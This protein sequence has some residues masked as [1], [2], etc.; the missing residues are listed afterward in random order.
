MKRRFIKTYL[1]VLFVLFVAVSVLFVKFAAATQ[2]LKDNDISSDI[3]FS[4]GKRR[5]RGDLWTTSVPSIN[6]MSP[7]KGNLI[8]GIYEGVVK[9]M[10]THS[11]KKWNLEITVTRPCYLNNAWNGFV[12][13][14]RN[15][16]L[17]FQPKIDLKKARETDFS[18]PTIKNLNNILIPLEPGDRIIFEPYMGK[19]IP[20]KV[21]DVN[22]VYIG[23]IFYTEETS[24]LM[25]FDTW[26]I[27]YQFEHAI[28]FHPLFYVFVVFYIVWLY[29]VAS[30]F[31]FIAVK[32]SEEHDRKRD[33]LTIEQV[34]KVFTRFIDAKD[35]YTAGH[36][37][38]VGRYS[39]KIAKEMGK[40][41]DECMNAYYCGLLHDCGKIAV[42]DEIIAKPDKLTDEE[43]VLMQEHTI[44]GYAILKD[45]TLIPDASFAAFYHHERFDG[46]GYPNGLKGEEIPEIVR[47]V[48]VAD[49][50]DCMSRDRYYRK[51]FPLE[52]IIEDFK[53]NSGKQFDP[54]VLNAFFALAEKGEFNEILK[55]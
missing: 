28:F 42:P 11:V 10:S 54:V 16:G 35:F 49:V 15:D 55:K 23:F 48:S 50:F 18:I 21:Q 33:K 22:S 27:N 26:K 44:M 53:K 12:E 31:Y 9:N 51:A 47:I 32:R 8:G 46:A 20:G 39:F 14:Y 19:F 24:G 40:S 3:N 6:Y 37:E 52:A 5:L 2:V 25:R 17:L 41:E 30:G 36:S 45:L 34:I 13:I 1:A 29:F 7:G 38:R 4:I 43:Y